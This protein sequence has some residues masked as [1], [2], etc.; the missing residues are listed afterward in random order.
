MWTFYLKSIL[1]TSNNL[2][3]GVIC[4]HE[5]SLTKHTLD[6]VVKIYEYGF[7]FELIFYHQE[8]L[9]TGSGRSLRPNPVVHK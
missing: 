3:M 9:S 8:L 6:P 7:E 5:N 2:H 1:S 4:R